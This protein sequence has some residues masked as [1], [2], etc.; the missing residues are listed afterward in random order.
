ML[1]GDIYMCVVEFY[2]TSNV[3]LYTSIS[4]LLFKGLV[5]F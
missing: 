2:T 3:A 5:S 4:I 1:D